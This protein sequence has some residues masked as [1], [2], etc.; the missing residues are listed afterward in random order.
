MSAAKVT[1][2]GVGG[3]DHE[4]VATLYSAVTKDSVLIFFKSRKMTQ[5]SPS[6]ASLPKQMPTDLGCCCCK[7][8]I[9]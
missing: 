8:A 7:C 2:G 6:C 4:D 9:V 3:D 1:T 5:I